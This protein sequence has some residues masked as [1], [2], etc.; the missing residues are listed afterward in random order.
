VLVYLTWKV[1]RLECIKIMSMIAVPLEGKAG[2]C[3][4]SKMMILKSID[5]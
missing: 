5:Y 3:W 2:G 1:I 4:F